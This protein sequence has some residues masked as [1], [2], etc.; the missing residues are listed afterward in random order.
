VDQ[1]VNLSRR[2]LLSGRAVST[3]LP[4]RPPGAIAEPLF[5]DQCTTCGDCIGACPEQIVIRGSAGYPEVDFSKGECTFCG[6]CIKS[7]GEDALSTAIQPPW[8]LQ[9]EVA[10]CCLAKKQVVCQICSDACEPQAIRFR[11]QIGRVATPDI[12]EELC[13]GCGACIASC[14]E[15]ALSAVSHG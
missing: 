4:L 12:N 2:N 7:C 5:A 13:T 3:V 15:N 14:P 10:D 9:I 6:E 11:P 1:P 8:N